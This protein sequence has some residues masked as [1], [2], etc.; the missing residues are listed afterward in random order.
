MTWSNNLHGEL[1]RQARPEQA[2]AEAG[3]AWPVVQTVSGLVRGTVGP[4]RTGSAPGLPS[5]ASPA[6]VIKFSAGLCEESP[7][8]QHRQTWW[9]Q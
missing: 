3:T 8:T 7:N 5:T 1:Y 9:T 6:I 4:V 2:V